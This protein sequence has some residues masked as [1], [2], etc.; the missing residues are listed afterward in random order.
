M[1]SVPNS[2]SRVGWDAIG[3]GAST[4]CV[5]HCMLFPVL[6]AFSPTL[7]HFVPGSE[8]IHRMF[9]YL[10]AAIGLVAFWAGY[11]VH[12]RKVVLLL[13]GIGVSGVT[14]G[15]YADSLLPTHSWEVLITVCGSVF[16]I[17]AHY[18]NRTL[19]LSCRVC[20]EKPE[21]NKAHNRS[22][23]DESQ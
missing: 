23:K 15:A 14:V 10:L 7:A 11:K 22:I 20:V 8:S 9:A 16:L 19:C 2:L 5:I 13:L 3:I 21:I 17:I 4:L 1:S 18:M 6:L 12:R